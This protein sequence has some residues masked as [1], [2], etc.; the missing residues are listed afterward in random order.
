MP[1][2]RL[3]K[4]QTERN[5]STD[6][7]SAMDGLLEKVEPLVNRASEPIEEVVRRQPLATIA[8]G[9]VLGVIAGCL[10]KRR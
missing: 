6:D 4:Y 9:I 3:A 8:A 10:I 2:N 5:G 1:E 7:V